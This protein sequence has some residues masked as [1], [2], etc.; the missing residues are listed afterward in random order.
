MTSLAVRLWF[1]ILVMVLINLALLL[2]P[3]GTWR[4]WQAWLFCALFYLPA[5]AISTYF[6]ARDP[7]FL[8]RRMQTGEPEPAQRTIMTFAATGYILI[9]PVAGFDHRF[10]WSYVPLPVVIAASVLYLAAYLFVFYVYQVNRF[11][12]ATIR[13]EAGQQVIDT[14]PYAVVRHPMYLGAGLMTLCAPLVLGSLWAL[15]PVLLLLAAVIFRLRNE[16]TVL[17]R[18]LPGYD[19]YR[20][21]VRW[22]LLPGI[23]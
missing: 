14:G 23:W 4:W 5:I 19:A 20:Q 7:A 8:E 10:G 22:R 6:L 16:E 18:D 15:L 1:S 3:A 12:A 9:F 2:F 13:V 21:R 17:L 11:A